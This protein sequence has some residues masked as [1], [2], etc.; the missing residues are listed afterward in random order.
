MF[1]NSSMVRGE[2]IVS[3]FIPS[4]SSVILSFVT[5]G[6]A[7]MTRSGLSF[8]IADISGFALLAALGSSFTASG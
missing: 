6:V 8:F 4:A 5:I 1:S 2:V 7:V 3:T